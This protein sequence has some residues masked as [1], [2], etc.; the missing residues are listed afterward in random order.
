LYR[1]GYIYSDSF[2]FNPKQTGH[3]NIGA[4]AVEMD[5]SV[6][7]RYGSIPSMRY[8]PVQDASKNNSVTQLHRT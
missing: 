3:Q 7:S 8:S 2:N 6:D 1:R 4:D 5:E